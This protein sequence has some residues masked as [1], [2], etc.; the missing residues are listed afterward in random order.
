M[1]LLQK[2]KYQINRQFNLA[3]FRNGLPHGTLLARDLKR[4]DFSP[5]VIFDVGANVGQSATEY[6][7]SWPEA[8]VYC[9]EPASDTYSKLNEN[10]LPN[11]NIS[12]FNLALGKTP[13]KGEL[14]IHEHSTLNSIKQQ[15]SDQSVDKQDIDIQT[16]D[17][18]CRETN[19]DE[20]DLL[21]IDTE[22]NDLNILK[23]AKE[24]M[25]CGRIASVLV[26]VGFRPTESTPHVPYESVR[27]YM[28]SQG[29]RVFGFYNQAIAPRAKELK[30]FDTL[31]VYRAS[32]SLA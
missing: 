14:F 15:R 4:I 1:R 26:E 12:T 29:F 13:R 19:I 20:I 18:F 11:N 3:V 22:G 5:S 2:L 21:K 17:S 10:I 6:A 9:F 32:T 25:D 16:I 27:D 23:G 7:A 28:E 24:L 30:R 8:H 31:F